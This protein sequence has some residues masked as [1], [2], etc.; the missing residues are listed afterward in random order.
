MF[1]SRFLFLYSGDWRWNQQTVLFNSAGVDSKWPIEH[2][3]S[4]DK[5][6]AQWLIEH[7]GSIHKM[8]GPL[9]N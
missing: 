8:F 6:L 1:L 7:T 4:I 5:G 9:A 2:T 3:G